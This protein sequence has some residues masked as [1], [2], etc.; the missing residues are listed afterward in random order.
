MPE[1]LKGKKTSRIRVLFHWHVLKCAC[2]SPDC[3]KYSWYIMLLISVVV[4]VFA[5]NIVLSDNLKY[6]PYP[7]SSTR[8]L[9]STIFRLLILILDYMEVQLD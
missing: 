9:V 3:K 7:P 2:L 6:L 4:N 1:F 8:D 5:V